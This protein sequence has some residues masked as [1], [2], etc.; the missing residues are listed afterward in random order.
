MSYFARVLVS[1][2]FILAGISK[3]GS[4]EHEKTI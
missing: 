4:E 3:L 2:I 1:V